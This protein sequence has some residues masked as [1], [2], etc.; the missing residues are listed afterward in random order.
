MTL[1]D[2]PVFIVLAVAGCLAVAALLIRVGNPGGAGPPDF[3]CDVCG[4]K[5]R[6]IYAK[7][8]RFCPYCGTPVRRPPPRW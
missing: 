7:E 8:W 3:T 4:R 5:Q 1:W 2:H 6:T